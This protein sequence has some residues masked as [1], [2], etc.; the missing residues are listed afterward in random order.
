VENTL[1]VGL[2]RQVALE[3]Q[4]DVIANNMANVTTSGFKAEKS[5][6]EEYLRSN[7]H[8]DQFTGIDRRVSFVQ[9]RATWHDFAQ[10][11]TEQTDNPLDVAI[12]GDGF[13]AVQTPNGQPSY[14]RNGA[15]QI[16]A[17]GQLVTTD[18][19]IVL[20]TNGPIVLQQGDS[21]LT[22]SGDGTVT[23]RQAGNPQADTIRG[24]LQI[25]SFADP[26]ALSKAGGSLFAAPAGVAPQ[27]PGNNRVIQGA[28][29]KSNVSAVGEMTRM[30]EVMR[31]YTSI[32]QMLQQQGDLHKTAI[33]RLAE[34][35]A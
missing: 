2:S 35:P 18:G 28:I 9:D 25:V 3:R 21:D 24:K 5:S 7:A 26:Q 27:P 30:I 4:L 11:A 19:N 16:N 12:D 22:I 29:E 33:Q 10:G 6:F 14:T 23:V 17:T 8:D 34:I 20:G 31:T 15:M 1:L 32:A 13:I